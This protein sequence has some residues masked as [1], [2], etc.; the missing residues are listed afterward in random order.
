MC[1]QRR[2]R[3][4]LLLLFF[5]WLV[6][7]SVRT[8]RADETSVPL[9]NP[10]LPSPEAKAP[11]GSKDSSEAWNDLMQAWSEFG[12][13]WEK[14]EIQLSQLG[15]GINELPTYLSSMHEQ[16][17]LLKTSLTAETQARL[18]AERSRD[19]WRAAAIAAGSALVL[20]LIF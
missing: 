16:V 11:N 4:L 15:I 2:L 6:P 12:P 18:K 9:P 19:L 7:V 1:R 17:G 20:S 14:L 3:S 8:L 10:S 13:I 5:F